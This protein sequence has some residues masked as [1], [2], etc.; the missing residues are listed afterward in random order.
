MAE[1][2]NGVV[3]YIDP[4]NGSMDASGYFKRGSAGGFGY[5]RMDDKQLTTDKTIIKATMEGRK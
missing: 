2:E 4:Q 5:F 3:R 1:K